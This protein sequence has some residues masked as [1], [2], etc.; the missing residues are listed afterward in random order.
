VVLAP[1]HSSEVCDLL[2]QASHAQSAKDTAENSGTSSEV[3]SF[4]SP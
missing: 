3:L 2:T 1:A 4:L